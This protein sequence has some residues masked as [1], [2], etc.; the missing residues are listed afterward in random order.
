MVNDV[1][2]Q[3][4]EV[5]LEQIII[6]VTKNHKQVKT[7]I[8]QK[9]NYIN[10]I[11]QIFFK[12]SGCILTGLDDEKLSLVIKI[13]TNTIR[14]RDISNMSRGITINSSQYM[15]KK[16]DNSIRI[17]GGTN[18]ERFLIKDGNKRKPNRFLNSDDPRVKK[19]IFNQKRIINQRVASSI[20][21]IVATIEN[22]KLP[23]DDT[24]NNIVLTDENF[25]YEDVL[26]I[27]N[28]DLI[29][30]Y[31]RCAIIND[32]TLTID[33]DRPYMGKIPIKNPKGKF[34]KII[35]NILQNK[36]NIMQCSESFDPNI[37]N[38]IK[39]EER[40]INDMIFELYGL[41]EDEGRRIQSII[42]PN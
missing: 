21:K 36:E 19:D 12:E 25:S 14:L 34:S 38:Q 35:S 33:L 16:Q 37:L 32:S 3:W 24:L 31:L 9:F 7:K 1:G 4:E 42:S 8:Y 2:K 29:T 23:T 40:K 11:P 10:E 27:L 39:H 18:V 28:S 6:F 13:E 41:T 26:A 5:G 17:L 30:F 15:S 22:E 20:P